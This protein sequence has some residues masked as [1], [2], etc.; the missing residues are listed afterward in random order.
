MIDRDKIHRNIADAVQQAFTRRDTI[1]KMVLR[2]VSVAVD[3]IIDELE[4]KDTATDESSVT[5]P[6]QRGK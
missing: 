4:K 1:N 5:R 3:S 6:R 2:V